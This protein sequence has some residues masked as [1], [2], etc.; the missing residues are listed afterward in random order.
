[1]ITLY[2][3]KRGTKGLAMGLDIFHAQ[4]KREVDGD[5]VRVDL[6][7]DE[8]KPLRSYVQ[9]HE[10]PHIDWEKMSADRGLELG[11]YRIQYHGTDGKYRCFAFSDANAVGFDAPIR[12]VFSDERQFSWLPKFMQRSNLSTPG[13]KKAPHFFGPFVTIMKAENV[14]FYDTVGYQHNGVSDEFYHCFNS[15]DV[16]CLEHQV[17]GIYQMT[18]PALREEFKR[19]FMDNWIVGRSF[20][21]VS[22]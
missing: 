10:N 19:T 14:I 17:E 22:Y 20:V 7:P 16:T 15:D 3:K 18:D 2:H 1:M 9:I 21:I 6:A 13:A 11:R 12:F 5:F 4:A 8:F